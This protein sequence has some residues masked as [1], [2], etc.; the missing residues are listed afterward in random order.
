MVIS[1]QGVDITIERVV[2][3]SLMFLLYLTDLADG[4]MARRLNQITEFGK[5]IDPVA[6]KV[7]IGAIVTTL[8]YLGD[9]PLWYVLVVIGRDIIILIAGA[10]ISTKIKFVLPS[11]RLGKYTVTS[12]SIVIVLATLGIRSYIM[13]AFITISIFMILA[14]LIGYGRRFFEHL[15]RASSLGIDTSK[16][17]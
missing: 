7:C 14:S 6:D 13:S 16:T 4:Y 3:I 17:K 1:I 10:Y 11:N 2:A 8:V 5:I 15:S 9:L 12:I